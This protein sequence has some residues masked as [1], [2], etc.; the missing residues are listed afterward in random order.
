MKRCPTDQSRVRA[1][2]TNFRSKDMNEPVR[3]S[4]V[5]I[6]IYGSKTYRP[7]KETHRG[8]VSHFKTL[9]ENLVEEDR[10]AGKNWIGR[11]V[12]IFTA[13]PIEQRGYYPGVILDYRRLEKDTE[14]LVH[15]EENGCCEWEV[16]DARM[17]FIDRQYQYEMHRVLDLR[18]HRIHFVTDNVEKIK[19]R[20]FFTEKEKRTMVGP[21]YQV[22]IDRALD[23]DKQEKM[24]EEKIGMIL[25]NPSILPPTEVARYL[26]LTAAQLDMDELLRKGKDISFVEDNSTATLQ[27]ALDTLHKHKYSVESANRVGFYW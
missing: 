4:R 23:V 3:T 10:I 5:G 22:D 19:Y 25:W 17:R 6:S 15:Y 11:R 7:E 2:V 27:T 8:R 24:E 16:V 9:E 20:L 18:R 26:D 1:N 14:Y 21:Q 12:E 13:Y